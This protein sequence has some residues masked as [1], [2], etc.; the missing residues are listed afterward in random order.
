MCE[1]AV[2]YLSPRVFL[3]P[4]GGGGVVH[5]FRIAA[6]YGGSTIQSYD[7]AS[8]NLYNIVSN[9]NSRSVFTFRSLVDEL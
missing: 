3:L 7:C 8:N 6:R 9:S 4:I 2:W 5:R 1:W